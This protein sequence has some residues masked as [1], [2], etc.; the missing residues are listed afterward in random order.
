MDPQGGRTDDVEEECDLLTPNEGRPIGSTMAKIQ[1]QE[2]GVGIL[3]AILCP[4]VVGRCCSRISKSASRGLSS[5]SRMSHLLQ[6]GCSQSKDP[7][8]S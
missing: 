1:K 6:H 2:K 3:R 8:R 4:A 7:L 5:L